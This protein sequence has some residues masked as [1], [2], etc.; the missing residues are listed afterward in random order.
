MK[1]FWKSNKERNEDYPEDIVERYENDMR[2]WVAMKEIN[3]L[4]RN[5]VQIVKR[6][7]FR[8]SSVCIF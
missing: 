5:G 2:N 4:Y 7:P 8:A 6:R 3:I 1:H